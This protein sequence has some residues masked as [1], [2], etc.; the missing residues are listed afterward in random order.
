MHA[1]NHGWDSSG[2]AHFRMLMTGCPLYEVREH[3]YARPALVLHHCRNAMRGVGQ[4]SVGAGDALFLRR[5]APAYPAPHGTILESYS[6][7]YQHA[8]RCIPTAQT[9][10][11]A[12]RTRSD[13]PGW[14]VRLRV[15]Q[16][17]FFPLE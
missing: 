6:Q 7:L 5:H 1:E 14:R 10:Q 2:E 15:F 3:V 16:L 17:S 11:D 13:D 8:E 12:P 9:E 4:P